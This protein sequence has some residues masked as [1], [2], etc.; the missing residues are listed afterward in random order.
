MPG[1]DCRGVIFEIL[2]NEDLNQRGQ[3]RLPVDDELEE[4]GVAEKQLNVVV[5]LGDEHVKRVVV[6]RP[7]ELQHLDH[8][9]DKRLQAVDR[10][11]FQTPRK[12]RK[13]VWSIDYRCEDEGEKKTS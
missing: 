1:I 10:L 9:L 4:R 6:Q 12:K 3:S 13:R 7:P 5:R 2:V 8:P 11:A